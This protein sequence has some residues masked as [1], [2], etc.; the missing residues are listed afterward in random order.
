MPIRYVSPLNRL[1]DV[2]MRLPGVGAKT[3]QRLAFYLLKA[4]REEAMKLAEAIVEIKEKIVNIEAG[5]N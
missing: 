4:S 2:L 5:L 1:V 3:A